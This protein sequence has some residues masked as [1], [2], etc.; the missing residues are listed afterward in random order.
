MNI[1]REIELLYKCEAVFKIPASPVIRQLVAEI[2]RPLPD[3]LPAMPKFVNFKWP[4]S[5]IVDYRLDRRPWNPW[6][7][8]AG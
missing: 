8:E 7:Q 2:N 5:E 3:H 4:K 1:R 6:R